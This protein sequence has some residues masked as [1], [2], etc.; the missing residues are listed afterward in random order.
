MIS[1]VVLGPSGQALR[2]RPYDQQWTWSSDP[3]YAT[4]LTHA[5]AVDLQRAI[6][7]GDLDDARRVESARI[8]PDYHCRRPEPVPTL[9]ARRTA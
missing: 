9:A 2:I 1:Y 5:D 4:P 8:V 3:Q 6:L 7:A